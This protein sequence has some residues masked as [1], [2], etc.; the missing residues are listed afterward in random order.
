MVLGASCGIWGAE[1]ALYAIDVSQAFMNSPLRD[2][3][4]IVL[5]MPLSI[6]TTSG[7]PIFLEAHKA[8]NGLRVASLTWCV[9]LKEIVSKIGLACSTTEPCLYG[10]VIDGSP[11]LLL[12]YV[13][14]LLIASSTDKAFHRVFKELSKH[15]KVRETGRIALGKDGGG[16]LKFLGRV[17]SRRAS[18]PSLVMQVDP[19]YM[20]AACEEFGIKVPK[21]VV[22]PPD[23]KPS[24]EATSE[25]SPISPEAHSRYRRVLGRLAWLAQTRMDLLHYTSLLASGQAEPKPGHEKALRQ[26]LRFVVTDNHVGQHEEL[27]KKRSAEGAAASVAEEERAKKKKADDEAAI[28]RKAAEAE[29]Q[30]KADEEEAQRIAKEEEGRKT[31]GELQKVESA[32]ELQKEANKAERKAQ[33]A[34]EKAEREPEESAQKA[35]KVRK[36]E[37]AKAKAELAKDKLKAE[38]RAVSNLRWHGNRVGMPRIDF[39]H[40]K[41]EG[42]KDMWNER[43]AAWKAKEKAKREQQGESGD[44]EKKSEPERPGDRLKE[45]RKIPVSQDPWSRPTVF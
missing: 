35:K 43:L 31:A 30:R 10:G 17:I 11:T 3:E 20:D 14:D 9:F 45:Q 12:C 29:A 23:I 42:W 4:R 18:S 41:P 1:L 32:Y 6:S 33:K 38:R 15:V 19:S 26:V 25:E 21:G 36:A 24:L 28:Q 37:K 22:G 27:R 5:K 44:K 40:D 34:A 16:S 7:E 2:K 13:D 8:L 39:L